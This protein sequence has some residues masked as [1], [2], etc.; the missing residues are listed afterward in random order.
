MYYRFKSSF[1]ENTL[2]QVIDDDGF[3]LPMESDQSL[4]L[5]SSFSLSLLETQEDSSSFLSSF[6]NLDEVQSSSLINLRNA[7]E[8]HVIKEFEAEEA[9]AINENSW[10]TNLNKKSKKSVKQLQPSN[11]QTLRKSMTEKLFQMSSFTKR[12]PRKSLSRNNL[13]S[14]GSQSSLLSTSLDTP[15]ETL[16]DLETILAQKALQEKANDLIK[17]PTSSNLKLDRGWLNRCNE[18]E[19]NEKI[20]VTVTSPTE[21]KQF[22]LSNIT[23]PTYAECTYGNLDQSD[24]EVIENSEDESDLKPRMMRHVLKKRKVSDEKQRNTKNSIQEKL[25]EKSFENRLESEKLEEDTYDAKQEIVEQDEKVKPTKGK[26]MKIKKVKP[27][28]ASTVTLRRSSR[29]KSSS[30]PL[31]NDD[32]KSDTDPF[33]YDS[34]SDPEF[35][36]DGQSDPILVTKVNESLPMEPPKMIVKKP[37]KSAVK[38]AATSGRRGRKFKKVPDEEP[39]Q[40]NNDVEDMPENYINQIEVENLRNI[41]RIDIKQLKE[42]TALFHE[43][44]KS[45]PTKPSNQPR[46]LSPTKRDLEREKL[47]KKIAAGKLNENFVRIDVRKKVFVRGKKTI[48]YSKY[49]KSKWKQ[50]KAANAL[51]G[52]EMD[53]RGC[54]GGFLVCFNCGQQGHYAQDCKIQCE[55]TFRS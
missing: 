41:P 49:K 52:P 23:I 14:S 9:N 2:S 42:D 39:E 29:V 51:A 34:H 27:K 10:G 54:D 37:T 6:S 19:G 43:Y 50:Q 32:S 11:S 45:N 24:D 15:K 4:Q 3:D 44:V 18:K 12:N 5:D 7:D 53:M 25:V 33:A 17:I 20:D 16:P 35:K 13:Q 40:F 46:P 22:G 47:E 36:P 1:L 31:E 21:P 55:Y 30:K 8:N 48:N 38:S 26:K 28:A